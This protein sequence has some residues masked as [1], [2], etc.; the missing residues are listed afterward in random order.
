MEG[1]STIVAYTLALTCGQIGG[2]RFYLGHSGSAMAMLM[3]FALALMILL[4]GGRSP[5]FAL[6]GLGILIILTVIVLIDLFRIPSLARGLSDNT[7]ME[8]N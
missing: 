4:L 5:E 8:V 7:K 3:S 6:F 1:K 2:H